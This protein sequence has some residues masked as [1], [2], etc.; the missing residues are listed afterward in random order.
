MWH[1]RTLDLVGVRSTSAVMQ[2]LVPMVGDVRG[3]A[4]MGSSSAF[5]G[6]SASWRCLAEPPMPT[7]TTRA[8]ASDSTADSTTDSETNESERALSWV[9]V[10]DMDDVRCERRE[11]GREPRPSRDV[12]LERGGGETVT[13][14][15]AKPRGQPTRPGE[16][17]FESELMLLGVFGRE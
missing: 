16:V 5:S 14:E 3:E 2:S 8:L 13:V 11:S 1:T 6:L 15:N 9:Q 7:P 10:S 12:V 17:G 4:S